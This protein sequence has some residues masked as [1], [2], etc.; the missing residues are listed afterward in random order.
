MRGLFDSTSRSGANRFTVKVKEFDNIVI[1]F[2]SLTVIPR[3][4]NFVSRGIS[5]RLLYMRFIYV[6]CSSIR[7]SLFG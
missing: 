2:F 1:Y 5:L 3:L 4:V 6:G 7:N